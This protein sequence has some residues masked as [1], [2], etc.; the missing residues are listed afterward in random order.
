MSHNKNEVILLPY[1]HRF[2]RLYVVHI[3]RRGHLGILSTAN[4]IRTR[5]WIV[6]LLKKVKYIRYNCVTCKKLDKRVSE[7]IPV[8][9][10]KPSPAWT[11]TSIDLFRPFKIRDVV[12]KRTTVKTYGVIFN[13]SS[14]RTVHVDLAEDYSTKK[15][16]MELRRFVSIRGHPSKLYTDNG[17]QL[18]AANEELKN[19]GKGWN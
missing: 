7:Q 1:N 2:S 5:F 6:K 3:H 11:C 19:V 14:N 8:E 13:C 17:P 16:L 9:R 18:V 12:K 10:L 4:K 15:F